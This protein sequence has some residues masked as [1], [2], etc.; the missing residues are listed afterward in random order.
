MRVPRGSGRAGPECAGVAQGRVCLKCRRGSDAGRARD[1]RRAR[2]GPAL[3]AARVVPQAGSALVFQLRAPRWPDFRP[4][5]GLESSLGPSRQ[6]ARAGG[7]AGRLSRPRRKTVPEPHAAEARPPGWAEATAARGA[8]RAASESVG[9]PPL[10]L[11]LAVRSKIRV[12]RDLGRCD[13]ATR[14]RAVGREHWQ[15]GRRLRVKTAMRPGRSW[16]AG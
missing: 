13:Q 9:L 10:A 3:P 7:D 6:R 1:G 12:F 4:E 11:R 16:A 8:R 15:V 2:E 5:A 14:A